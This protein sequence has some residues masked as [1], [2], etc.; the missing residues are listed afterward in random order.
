MAFRHTAVL[1]FGSNLGQSADILLSAWGA[2]R[3]TAGVHVWKISSP[4]RSHPVAMDSPHWFVNAVGLLQT[5]HSP[6]DLLRILQSIETCFGR[7]RN[8]MRAG[9]QDRTLDLDLLLYDDLVLDTAELTIPHPRMRERR[10]VLEP[11]LEIAESIRL[12][13]F[14]A[15]LAVWAENC[16]GAVMDQQVERCAWL[17]CSQETLP[18]PEKNEP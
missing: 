7:V 4:Y 5:T 13:P 2:L 14:G 10:F 16:L 15:P 17:K 8:P 11:L 3:D 1:G 18:Q 9:Y 6:I 12:T